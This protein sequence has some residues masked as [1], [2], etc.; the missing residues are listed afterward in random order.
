VGKTWR[1]VIAVSETTESA[2]DTSLAPYV[3]TW[4]N[5]KFGLK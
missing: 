5:R 3:P 2:G 4:N 1:Q